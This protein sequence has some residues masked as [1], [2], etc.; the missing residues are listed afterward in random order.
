MLQF[1]H[2]LMLQFNHQLML[3]FNHQLML[4]FKSLQSI[5][6]NQEWNHHHPR[7]LEL[8]DKDLMLLEINTQLER[9]A[10]D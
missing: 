3:Q 1:N 9:Q 7:M 10:L 6:T 8:F 5:Y 4:Q 2:Q